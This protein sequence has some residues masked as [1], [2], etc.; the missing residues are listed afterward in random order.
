MFAP[1]S[2]AITQQ[3]FDTVMLCTKSNVGTLHARPMVVADID[4]KDR[5]WFVTAPNSIMVAEIQNNRDVAL[6]MQ[7][8]AAYA[9]ISGRASLVEVNDEGVDTR[10]GATVPIQLRDSSDAVVLICVEPMQ[11]AFWSEGATTPESLSS[12]ETKKLLNDVALDKDRARAHAR[13]S[14]IN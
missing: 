5:W 3:A 14:A 10:D 1:K 2:S 12:E 4:S 6:T 11:T 8:R 13:A 7:S 9:C